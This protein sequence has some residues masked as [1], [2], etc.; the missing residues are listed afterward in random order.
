MASIR[1]RAHLVHPAAQGADVGG[2][3]LEE[4]PDL[5]PYFGST[6]AVNASLRG[7]VEAARHMR[8]TGS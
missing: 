4:M 3:L 5:A 7:L 6:E 2:E 8:R 1:S